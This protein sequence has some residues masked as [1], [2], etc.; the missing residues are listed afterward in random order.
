MSTHSEGRILRY[1]DA[2]AEAVAQEMARDPSVF[3]MGLDVDDHRAIQGSTRGLLE[4]FGAD[5]VFTTPLSEDAMTG[6]AIG[7]RWPGCGRS[8]FISGWI[9]CCCA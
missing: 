2:L 7:V 5:R 6:V 1:V 4:K 9:S 8:M 3:V